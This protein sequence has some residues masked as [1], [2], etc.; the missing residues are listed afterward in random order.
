MRPKKITFGDMREM[1]VRGVLIYCAD[2]RCSH[3][4]TISADRWPDKVR[5]SDIE[6][7]FVCG[8]RGA[9]GL[10]RI[11]LGKAARSGDWV[12]VE[13]R[14]HVKRKAVEGVERRGRGRKR[15]PALAQRQRLDQA[16]SLDR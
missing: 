3:S 12:S 4:V 15:A 7:R 8:R 1:G 11:Q 10:A 14:E 9:D 5:L 13:L 6:P 2:Y 16:L